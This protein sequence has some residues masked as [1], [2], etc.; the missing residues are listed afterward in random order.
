MINTLVVS[1]EINY[2]GSQLSSLWALRNF[3]V[4]G[5]SIVAFIGACHVDL[6]SLVDVRDYLDNAPIYSPRM[7]HF[8][9]EHFTNDLDRT[10]LCQ[11]LFIAIIKDIVGA[12]GAAGLERRGDDLYVQDRKLSV[13]IAT[14]T[15]VSTMIHTGL[16][17]YTKGAP[18]PA[19]GLPELGWPDSDAAILAEQVCAAYAQEIASVRMARCKVRGVR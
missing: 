16:N 2:D 5:D 14:V 4:Q 15:P 3:N 11:R 13:S 18:V 17:I 9:V 6:R 12:R 19:I 8:I 1:R 10:V 7:L